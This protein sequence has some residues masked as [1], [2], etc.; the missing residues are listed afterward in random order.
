MN[1]NPRKPKAAAKDRRQSTGIRRCDYCHGPLPPGSSTWRKFCCS[2]CRHRSW[3][4]ADRKPDDEAAAPV[5]FGTHIRAHFHAV[6]LVS[7]L[8]G[9]NTSPGWFGA[10]CPPECGGLRPGETAEPAPTYWRR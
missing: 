4:A 10:G 5:V 7:Y 2:R 9:H 3:S 6:G 8:A 1:A